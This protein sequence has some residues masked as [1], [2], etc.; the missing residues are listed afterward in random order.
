MYQ[1]RR[2][3]SGYI[4]CISSKR[5]KNIKKDKAIYRNYNDVTICE[6]CRQQRAKEIHHMIGGKNRNNS[7]KYNLLIKVCTECHKRCHSDL[8][9]HYKQRGQELFEEKFGTREEFIIIF[10]RNYLGGE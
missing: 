1:R 7:T 3:R 8:N 5:K 6:I 2:K 9:L 10:G 4:K